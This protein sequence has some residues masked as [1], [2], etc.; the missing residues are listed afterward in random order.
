[1]RRERCPSTPALLAA[2][3]PGVTALSLE[4]A[5]TK[6]GRCSLRLRLSNAQ[7]QLRAI[8]VK[9]TQPNDYHAPFCCNARW[10]AAATAIDIIESVFGGRVRKEAYQ[11]MYE[12]GY[13]L[14]LQYP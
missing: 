1:M 9:S 11:D 8:F 14:R 4:S 5:L 6:S 12:N 2:Q 10:M 13:R 3:L 7:V